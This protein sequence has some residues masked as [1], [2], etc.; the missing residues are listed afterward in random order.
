[1]VDTHQ[2]TLKFQRILQEGEKEAVRFLHDLGHISNEENFPFLCEILR[3]DYNLKLKNAAAV[4]LR[5]L[6]DDRAIPILFEAINDPQ[7]KDRNGTFVY[8]LQKLDC[9]GVI[10]E[11]VE[12]I[13]N[14]DYEVSEMAL[15]A[16]QNLRSPIPAAAKDKASDLLNAKLITVCQEGWPR[17]HP[18]D[19]LSHLEGL[20]VM[21]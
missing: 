12:L 13:C 7:N 10:I 16:I 14:G 8:A 1:M 20:H 9:R 19:A 11:L 21:Q 2:L 5:D 4:G 3:S 18:A 15:K 17:D 6:G